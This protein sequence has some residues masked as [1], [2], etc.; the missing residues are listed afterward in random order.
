MCS[1]GLEREAVGSGGAHADRFSGAFE[2][3]VVHAVGFLAGA[4]EW[5]CRVESALDVQRNEG[6]AGLDVADGDGGS[7]DRKSVV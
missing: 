5:D 6:G 4:D 3:G 7:L 2:G 1:A